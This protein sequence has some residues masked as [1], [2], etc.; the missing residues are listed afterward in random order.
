M[1]WFAAVLVPITLIYYYVQVNE[2]RYKLFCQRLWSAGKL[3]I[4][5]QY[6]G[7]LE[8]KVILFSVLERR[9][10]SS[11]R[12]TKFGKNNNQFQSFWLNKK[13][14]CTKTSALIESVFSHIDMW[15]GC[16]AS[17]EAKA[18]MDL[19]VFWICL[20][21]DLLTGLL[22]AYLK[23]IEKNYKCYNVRSLLTS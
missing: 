11:N 13:W 7:R 23:R 6:S 4:T 3:L 5:P 15:L 17:A 19:T 9:V 10:S 12:G 18:W 16:C 1:P 22:S 2:I 21:N 8:C 20:Q 14:N